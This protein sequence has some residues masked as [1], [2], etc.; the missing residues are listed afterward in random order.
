MIRQRECSNTYTCNTTLYK[1]GPL[2]MMSKLWVA[3]SF[4]KENHCS[5]GDRSQFIGHRKDD[6]IFRPCKPMLIFAVKDR[7]RCPCHK[8][9]RSQILNFTPSKYRSSNVLLHLQPKSIILI[10]QQMNSSF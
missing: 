9:G 3:N 5:Y 1:A 6:G 10:K 7:P 4:E 2:E 8:K